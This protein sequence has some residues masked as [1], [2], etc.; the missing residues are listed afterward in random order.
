MSFEGL[1][2]WVLETGLVISLL[3]ILILVIRRPFARWFGPTAAYAL[4]SL[5]FIRLCLPVLSIPESWV[6]PAFRPETLATNSPP[7]PAFPRI[8]DEDLTA[9][10]TEPAATQGATLSIFTILMVVWVSV[11]GLWLTYQL[12]RQRAFKL[13]LVEESDL[14]NAEL[15]AEVKATA[16]QVGLGKTPIVRIS[17]RE[18]GPLITGVVRPLVVLPHGFEVDF[19]SDQRGFALIHEFAHLKRG[20]LWI[21]FAVLVFRAVNWPNPLVHFASHR[22]RAD[23]E[24]A[25]DAFVVRVTGQGATHSYA[26]TLVKAARRS[27]GKAAGMGQLALSLAEVEGVNAEGANNKGDER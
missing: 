21:A 11:A 23:Q 16:K 17:D 13:R 10:L 24:A 15:A 22:L 3:I 4:W 19:E 6:P 20:D 12:L 5:P 7:P 18:I 25:C 27:S 9:Y 1:Q 14:P 2:G 26:E 8:L